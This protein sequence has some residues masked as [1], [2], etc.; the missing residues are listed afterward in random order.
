MQ[1]THIIFLLAVACSD[2]Y[3]TKMKKDKS[4]ADPAPAQLPCFIRP[5]MVRA[6]SPS[7]SSWKRSLLLY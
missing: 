4:A 1:D 2:F 6:A 5:D 7:P 3:R